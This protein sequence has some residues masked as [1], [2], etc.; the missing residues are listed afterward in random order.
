[1]RGLQVSSVIPVFSRFNE[2]SFFRA[3]KKGN[4]NFRQGS[5]KKE[6]C[7]TLRDYKTVGNCFIDLTNGPK[8][9][10]FKPTLTMLKVNI[11]KII[12]FLL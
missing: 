5:L 7:E 4:S 1:M 10:M 8:V 12:N 9:Y 2:V 6:F 11:S 3:G